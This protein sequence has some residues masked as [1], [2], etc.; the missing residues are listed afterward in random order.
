MKYIIID[1]NKNFAKKLCEQLNTLYKANNDTVSICNEAD[2]II[3]QDD[4]LGEL[5]KSIIEMN[6][7]DNAVIFIN[8]NLKTGE[9]TRKLFKGIELIKWLRLFHCYNHCVIYSFL[10]VN[11]I[12][13]TNPLNAI[14]LSKGVSFIELPNTFDALSTNEKAD[15]TNLLPFIRAE[16][17]LPK[18]RHELANIWG[19]ERMNWLLNIAATSKQNYLI[20]VLK[21][22]TPLE[23]LAQIDTTELNELI[24][25]FNANGK[26]IIYY[27]DMKDHWLPALKKLLGKNNVTAYDPKQIS[28]QI[29]FTNFIKPNKSVGCVLLDLRLENEKDIKDVLDYSGGKLLHEL[30]KNRISLPVIMFTASNKAETV[31]KLLEAGADYVWTKEGIDSGINNQYTLSNALSLLKEVQ[32]SLSK[33]AN[34]SYEKIYEADFSLCAVG[35]EGKDDALYNKLLNNENLKDIESIYFDTNFLINSVKDKY[36]DTL[37]KL[38]L[39]NQY[40]PCKKRIIIHDDV[41]REIFVISQQDEKNI[42]H[43]KNNPYR[44][45]VCR[46]LLDKI[47]QWNQA[48]LIEF[49]WSGGQASRISKFKALPYTISKLPDD[50]NSNLDSIKEKRSFFQKIMDAFGNKEEE[51]NIIIKDVQKQIAEFAKNNKSNPDLSKLELHAD[52]TFRRIIPNASNAGTVALITDDVGCNTAVANAV[53]KYGIEN[54]YKHFANLAFINLLKT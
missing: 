44:V 26:T 39:T 5:S 34:D 51:R 10:P 29:L 22:T 3:S 53:K 14:V 43:E 17:D 1:D 16:I 32:T 7:P 52:S 37:Y 11:K 24:S 23:N 19:A 46:F 9:N 36:L 48:Q 15:K 21:F 45:P 40:L 28:P 8:A 13:K 30:K 41:V 27:D 18:I 2:I 20:E 42:E 6:L 47:F 50:I 33:Y 4:K 49:M 35:V 25:N 31:R 54:N 12:I 38:I